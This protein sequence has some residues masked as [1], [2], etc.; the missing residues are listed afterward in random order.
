METL[1]KCMGPESLSNRQNRNHHLMESSSNT[2][3]YYIMQA[4]NI[5]DYI[6]G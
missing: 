2:V 5:Y 1:S 3:D 4:T 6:L